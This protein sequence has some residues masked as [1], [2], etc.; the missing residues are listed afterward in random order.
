MKSYLTITTCIMN[1]AWV[2]FRATQFGNSFRFTHHP[3]Y[4]LQL[5]VL[6]G[7]GRGRVKKNPA[8]SD[9]TTLSTK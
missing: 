7:G 6:N 9:S 4:T 3:P 5:T 8:A 2:I 1:K